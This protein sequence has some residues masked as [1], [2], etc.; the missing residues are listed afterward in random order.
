MFPVWGCCNRSSTNIATQSFMWT[1]VSIPL[2]LMLWSIT[3]GSYD[4][5]MYSHVR[6]HQ[7]SFPEYLTISHSHQQCMTEGILCFASRWGLG[8][9]P[10]GQAWL[11][12]S[13]ADFVECLGNGPRKRWSSPLPR[14]RSRAGVRE[15]DV[16]CLE[17]SRSC[18]E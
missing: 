5:H 14:E 11:V 12:E 7:N 17:V 18:W 16:S 13:R 3:S 2:A 15:T 6:N 4:K 9:N 1:Y 8:R 10:P